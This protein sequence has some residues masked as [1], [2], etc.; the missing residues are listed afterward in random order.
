MKK[1]ARCQREIESN[2]GKVARLINLFEQMLNF[3]N[4]KGTSTNLLWKILLVHV[5]HKENIIDFSPQHSTSRGHKHWTGITS[6]SF[7]S[8]TTTTMPSVINTWQPLLLF[9][10]IVNCSLPL[11]L[12]PVASNSCQ[13]CASWAYKN[14]HWTLTH[15]SSIYKDLF[16][17]LLVGNPRKSVVV[18]YQL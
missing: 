10:C 17:A 18:S 1:E 13:P 3:K 6:P 12:L 16:M 8:W 7:H 2:K 9:S 15:Q 14:I 11:H 4:R 5:P